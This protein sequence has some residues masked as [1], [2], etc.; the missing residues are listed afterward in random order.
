MAEFKWH[1]KQIEWRVR[2]AVADALDDL[3]RRLVWRVRRALNIPYPPASD[4]GNPPHRRT[5]LLRDS[6]F[7]TVN[8]HQ[9]VLHLR[10]D[11]ET[12]YWK[13]LEYGTI[14]MAP[15]PFLGVTLDA[16]QTTMSTEIR[17]L[18]KRYYKMNV[19]SSTAK[20]GAK[21]KKGGKSKSRKSSRKPGS[22]KETK[23]LARSAKKKPKLN[24][25]AK[26]NRRLENKFKKSQA[27]KNKSLLKRAKKT[28]KKLV[29]KYKK[30]STKS[31]FD[32][33]KLTGEALT[34][35][36]LKQA[37]RFQ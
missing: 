27:I 9:L 12:F 22:R 8:R 5:G 34:R 35:Y 23:K 31:A 4:P 7:T 2:N 18:I 29:K 21:A 10:V 24:A 20:G 14:K 19:S 3:G 30:K 6:I 11:E 33:L 26:R 37:R 15:R 36:I 28:A 16:M 32:P 13:F 25:A 1:G 17:R